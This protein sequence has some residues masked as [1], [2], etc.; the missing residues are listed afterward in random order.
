V[1]QRSKAMGSVQ[2]M[3]TWCRTYAKFSSSVY[4]SSPARMSMMRRAN[5]WQ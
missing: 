3:P 4:F 2:D 1:Y 5:R